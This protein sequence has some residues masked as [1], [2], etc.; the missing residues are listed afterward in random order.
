MKIH[1]VT[2]CLLVLLLALAAFAFFPRFQASAAS[3]VVTKGEVE[4]ILHTDAGAGAQVLHAHPVQGDDDYPRAIISPLSSQSGAHYCV[5]D[6]H[7][8][9][10][11]DFEGVDNVIFF[12]KEQVISDLEANTITLTLDGVTLPV[13]QTPIT[14]FNTADQHRFGL[15]G[16]A[17][18]FEAG[19]ILSPADLSV[20]DHTAGVV[21]TDPVFGTFTDSSTFTV[22]ASGTGVCLQPLP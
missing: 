1:R 14:K 18:G 13:T 22:D 5:D 17:Y 8:V 11:G 21:L 3:G 2:C 7:L 9:R 20:G 10:I 19:S 6:W 12:T 16:P 4:F 15:P